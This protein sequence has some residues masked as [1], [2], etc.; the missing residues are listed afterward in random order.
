[1]QGWDCVRGLPQSGGCSERVE[2]VWKNG[3]SGVVK[4]NAAAGTLSVMPPTPQLLQVVSPTSSGRHEARR[5]HF[6]QQTNCQL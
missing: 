3:S 1:M 4:S 2:T 5:Q 6:E